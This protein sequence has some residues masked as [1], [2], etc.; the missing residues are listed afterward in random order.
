MRKKSLKCIVTFQTTTQAMAFE[1]L[2]KKKD[3]PGRLIPVPKELTTG[4]GL[5]WCVE[6]KFT[7]LIKKMILNEKLQIDKIHE[8]MH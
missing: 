7:E 5:A 4:C 1:M 3:I 6:E 2:C 8:I